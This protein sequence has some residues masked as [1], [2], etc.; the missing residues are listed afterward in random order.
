MDAVQ[1]ESTETGS[2]ARAYFEAIA[3]RDLET[4]TSLWEPDGAGEIHGI[5]EL[6]LPDDTYRS[7]FATL[8]D[9]FPDFSCEILEMV[10]AGDKAAVRW[11]GGG[12][13]D[14]TAKF[15]GLDPTGATLDVTGFDLLTVRDGKIQR[16]DAYM[17]GA[18]IGQQLGAL[19]DPDSLQARVMVAFFNLT[20]RLKRSLSRHR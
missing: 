14:G 3:A 19:P 6:R 9:A 5:A 1:G 10:V 13:F 8:F 20:T 4:M 2:I 17:N 7:W 16:N 15:E 12:T 18:Q 11:R